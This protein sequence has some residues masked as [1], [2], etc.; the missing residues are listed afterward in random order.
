MLPKSAKGACD[1]KAA[2]ATCDAK[3]ICRID[4]GEAAPLWG[5][6]FQGRWL[7]GMN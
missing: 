1:P 3:P 4:Q 6:D 7:S 2:E 5:P